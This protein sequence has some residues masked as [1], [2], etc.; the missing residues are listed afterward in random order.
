M[1]KQR[2]K[3][4]NS[5]PTPSTE[6]RDVTGIIKATQEPKPP[7]VEAVQLPKLVVVEAAQ[8]PKFVKI[9]AVQPP[10]PVV[11]EEEEADK[12]EQ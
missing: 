4:L 12:G 2:R 11:I 5:E 3:R 1:T 8:P 9:E 7:K 6:V 10:E